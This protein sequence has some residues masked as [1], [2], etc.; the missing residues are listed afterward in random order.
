MKRITTL[1]GPSCAGK[2]T[3]EDLMVTRGCLGA[4]SHTTRQPRIGEENHVDYYFID[5]VTFKRLRA[6]GEFIE[7]VQFGEHF[8]GVSKAEIK[9]QFNNGDHIILVCEPNGAKQISEWAK[10]RQDFKLTS[11]FIDSPESVTA[12]RFLRR[13][14]DSILNSALSGKLQQEKAFKTAA[15]RMVIMGGIEKGWR[16]EAYGQAHPRN[17]DEISAFKYDVLIEFFDASNQDKVLERLTELEPV[18]C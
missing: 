2:S 17:R 18:T 12:D 1:T 13:T 4:I 5:V 7:A 3:L 11:V 14:F 10:T 6:Q 8:Y 9:R 15:E 16:A